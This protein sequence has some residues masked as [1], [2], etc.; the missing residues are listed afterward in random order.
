VGLSNTRARLEQLYG[1]GHRFE[2]SN[3]PE[4]GLLVTVMIPLHTEKR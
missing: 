2:I 4:G 1:R 3:A